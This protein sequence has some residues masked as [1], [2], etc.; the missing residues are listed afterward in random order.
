MLTALRRVPSSL[1]VVALMMLSHGAVAGPASTCTV[2][3]A[4]GTTI[5]ETPLIRNGY[6]TRWNL[7]TDRLAYM[8]RDASGYYSIYT[9]RPDGSG[10]KRL[11]VM[12]VHRAGNPQY[13][14]ELQVATTLA[15]S[16]AGD[17]FLGD[18]SDSLTRQTGNV[19][20]FRFVCP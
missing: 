8:Q 16:A 7:A 5:D 19:R 10:R 9:M 2:D 13:T 17:Y 1:G 6:G 12:N 18:V 4:G 14:G 20:V 11:T 3:R 15:V